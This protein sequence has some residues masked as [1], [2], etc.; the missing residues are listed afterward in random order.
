ME[1]SLCI[2]ITFSFSLT[3]RSTKIIVVFSKILYLFFL[4]E[5]SN[6]VEIIALLMHTDRQCMRYSNNQVSG[7]LSSF[8][9]PRKCCQGHQSCVINTFPER[10][11]IRHDFIFL[12]IFVIS[13]YVGG[14]SLNRTVG[15]S[16]SGIHI[17]RSNCF[18]LSEH[19]NNFL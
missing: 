2:E 19:L 14:E 7:L 16:Y 8:K 6:S 11:S 5:T 1:C 9:N 12:I 4:V 15:V 18:D 10:S 3:K 13:L 17:G